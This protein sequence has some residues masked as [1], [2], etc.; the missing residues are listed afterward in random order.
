MRYPHGDGGPD[1]HRDEWY[2]LEEDP[3]ELHNL[4]AD[5]VFAERVGQ[6]RAELDRLMA[7]HQNRSLESMPLDEGIKSELPAVEIQ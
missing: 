4:A 5:P 1:R 6:L 3:G 7:E 2:D